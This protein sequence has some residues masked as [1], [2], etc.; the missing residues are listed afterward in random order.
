MYKGN[1]RLRYN[2]RQDFQLQ[3]LKKTL[4]YK[5]PPKIWIKIFNVRLGF[6]YYVV[7]NLREIMKYIE[8]HCNWYCR[9]VLAVYQ[10]INPQYNDNLLISLGHI[11][12]LHDS[13]KALLGV[14]YAYFPDWQGLPDIT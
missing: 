8:A 11:P 14:C 1:V 4:L 7:T 9:E 12:L 6:D 10:R 5:L 3:F 2:V 13:S